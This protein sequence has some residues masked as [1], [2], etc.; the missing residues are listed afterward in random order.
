MPNPFHPFSTE[1]FITLGIGL[2][3][4]AVLI[5][6]GSRGGTIERIATAILAFFCLAAYPMSQAA[7]M[8]LGEMDQTFDNLLPFH[9]CDIAAVLAGFAL[10]T[11]NSLLCCLTYYW[12]LAATVQALLTPAINVGFPAWPFTVFFLQHFAIVGVALYLPIVYGWRPQRPFWKSPLTAY[13][14]ILVYLGA[15]MLINLLLDA[16]FGFASRP[17]E[18]PSLIDHLGPWPW[19]L[20]SMSAIALALFFL[21]TLP[22]VRRKSMVDG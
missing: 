9:L 10:L 19:Y 13:C 4:L 14:W 11:R 12:G 18:N 5:L 20:V 16:N 8:T 17:P 22:F 7:W 6:M 1:H 3:V 15:A 2:A 21:L